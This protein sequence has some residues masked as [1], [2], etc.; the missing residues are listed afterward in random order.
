MVFFFQVYRIVVGSANR[1][2]T[3]SITDADGNFQLQDLRNIIKTDI[4]NA[5]CTFT[6]PPQ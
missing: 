6:Y 3:V 4:N 5:V 1:K 2:V